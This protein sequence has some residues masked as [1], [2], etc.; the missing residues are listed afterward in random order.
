MIRDQSLVSEIMIRIYADFN[1][2][3][4]FESRF[5]GGRVPLFCNGGL[6]DIRAHNVE[7]HKGLRIIVYDDGCEA[8]AIVEKVRGDWWARIAG[9]IRQIP[10]EEVFK[11]ID[12]S[13]S[14]D[15]EG[16]HGADEEG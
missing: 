4:E 16:D 14:K 1:A 2:R 3:E 8:E 10:R 13:C 5:E 12:S 7:L 9:T 11:R 15:N 6:Q